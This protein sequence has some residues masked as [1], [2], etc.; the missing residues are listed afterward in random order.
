MLGHHESP[1]GLSPQGFKE[2]RKLARKS[3][4]SFGSGPGLQ[5]QHS[6]I[7]ICPRTVLSSARSF[8][9]RRW[10]RRSWYT[11]S[12]CVNPS[13][14]KP[15]LYDPDLR[16]GYRVGQARLRK[17]AFSGSVPTV[18]RCSSTDVAFS[19]YAM[20]ISTTRPFPFPAEAVIDPRSWVPRPEGHVVCPHDMNAV[21]CLPMLLSVIDGHRTQRYRGSADCS[22]L[23]F[24]TKMRSGPFNN[25]RFMP[26]PLDTYFR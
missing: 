13:G 8:S 21:A 10:P 11:A 16:L 2:A 17:S 26:L 6:F 9:L 7:V 15:V 14:D 22:C 25:R 3:G 20:R 12:T 24:S 5:A 19:S 23:S 18:H 4:K 1:L